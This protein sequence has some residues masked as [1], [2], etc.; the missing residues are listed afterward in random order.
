MATQKTNCG[1]PN[2]LVGTSEHNF[3]QYPDSK[4]QKRFIPERE[5]SA[6]FA[7]LYDSRIGDFEHEPHQLRRILD[8]ENTVAK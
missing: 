5:Y 2:I 3:E 4:Y 8:T 7:R 1:W 6:S